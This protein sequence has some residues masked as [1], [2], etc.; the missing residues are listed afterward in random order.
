MFCLQAPKAANAF[1]AV[2]AIS[3]T[4]LSYG[5]A[6]ACRVGIDIGHSQAQPGAISATGKPEYEFNRRFAH[7]LANRNS[8]HSLDLIILNPTGD[9]LDLRQRP[10]I[11]AARKVDLLL[12]I[13]HD[14]VNQKYIKRWKHEGYDLK[15]SDDFRG[16]SL[17]IWDGA[18]HA[19]A[20]IAIAK[21]LGKH[22]RSAGAVPTLHHA[23]PISG[24][25]RRLIDPT[26]G[27]YAAP[28]AV[29]KQAT[30]PA[31]LYEVGIIANR[32]EEKQLEEPS[33]RARLQLELLAG[34]AALCEDK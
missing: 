23:E 12:S 8:S 25:N 27:V 30:M 2:T 13:H 10:R 6:Q 14:S 15:Y 33:Q 4:L 7:E 19:Q 21:R 20:S 22:L 11:A 17:F 18:P 31:V 34:L 16:Y 3:I 9:D 5:Q 29:L 1:L 32:E 24:E 26:L 28:F